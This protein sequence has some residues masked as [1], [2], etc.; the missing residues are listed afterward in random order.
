MYIHVYGVY[1]HCCDMFIH[2]IVYETMHDKSNDF[3]FAPS[4]DSDQPGLPR[5]ANKPM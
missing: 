5:Y 2:C 1:K 3:D 4:E